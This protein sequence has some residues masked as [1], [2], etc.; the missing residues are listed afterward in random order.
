MFTVALVAVIIIITVVVI[1]ALA[2]LWSEASAPPR[3]LSIILNYFGPSASVPV[4][5]VVVALS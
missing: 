1:V 3:Q 4:A 5:N 2:F